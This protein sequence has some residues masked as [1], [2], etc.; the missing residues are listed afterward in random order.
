MSVSEVK[1]SFN[2]WILYLALFVLYI[3]HNDLWFW[4]D[5]RLF[6]GIPIGLLYHIGFCVAVSLILISL[7]NFAWTSDLK[8]ENQKTSES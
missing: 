3:L 5:P 7:V 4:N 1:K 2:K 6:L 8:V